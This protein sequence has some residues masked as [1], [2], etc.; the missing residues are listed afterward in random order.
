MERGPTVLF[1]A[2]VAVGLGPALW[3]GAQFGQ[4]RVVTVPPTITVVERNTGTDPGGR[5]AAEQDS[6]V[7]S[8][9]V[10]DDTGPLSTK[11]SAGPGRDAPRDTPPTVRVP[12]QDPPA[13]PAPTATAQPA[14]GP[15]TPAPPEPSTGDTAPAEPTPDPPAGGGGV[16]PDRGLDT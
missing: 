13:R 2:I 9:K 5:G 16:T 6:R 7:L 10:S 8:D 4:A 11:R 3:L 12:V 14:P 15:T 1:G